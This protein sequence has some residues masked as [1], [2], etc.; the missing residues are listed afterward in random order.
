MPIHTRRWLAMFLVSVPGLLG[1]APGARAWD[2]GIALTPPMG[3]N[4]WNK[5]GCNVSEELIKS[6]A[7]AMAASGMKDAGY[8]YVV[9]DDCWQVSRCE[10][11][12]LD[13]VDLQVGLDGFAGP[14][15]WS[16]PDMMEVGNGRHDRSGI[17][18]AFQF[19]GVACRTVNCRK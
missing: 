9:I 7:D 6:M 15:H 4:S 10:N 19:L 16:D 5:F 17:S 3:W 18:R 8:Q 1:A 14:G 13:I 11:G 2:N 12:L